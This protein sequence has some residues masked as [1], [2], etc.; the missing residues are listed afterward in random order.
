MA[1]C[2][3]CA[4]L[5]VSILFLSEYV[6]AAFSSDRKHEKFAVGAHILVNTQ[7]AVISRCCFCRERLRNVAKFYYARAEPSVI[8][9][10]KTLLLYHVLVAV[11][12]Y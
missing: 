6:D 1:R 11:L 2:I 8:L 7:N 5:T 3:Q 12:V 10:I 4:G 9:Q